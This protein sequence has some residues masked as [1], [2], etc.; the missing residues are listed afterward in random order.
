VLAYIE[1]PTA[2][3]SDMAAFYAETGAVKTAAEH[4]VAV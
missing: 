4:Q 2:D 1:E 3:P